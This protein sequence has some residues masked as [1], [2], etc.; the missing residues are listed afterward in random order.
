MQYVV[1][2]VNVKTDGKHSYRCVRFEGFTVVII[3]NAVFWVATPCSFCTNGRFGEKY[4]HHQGGRNRRSRKNV[5]SSPILFTLMMEAIRSSETSVFTRAARRHIPEDG[6]LHSLQS[7]LK[8]TFNAEHF[9][10][11][12]VELN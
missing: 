9:L 5:P 7:L 1:E 12:E 4:H 3:K 11:T 8:H 10:G 6:I 2:L